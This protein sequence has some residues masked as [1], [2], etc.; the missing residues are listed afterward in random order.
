MKTKCPRAT[1]RLNLCPTGQISVKKANSKEM[2]FAGLMWPA[3]RMLPPRD[4][5][6]IALF[7]VKHQKILKI[8]FSF[9][10][11]DF[12]LRL[13]PEPNLVSPVGKNE[14]QSAVASNPR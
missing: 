7:E 12:T 6:K 2:A 3:G 10:G 4:H 8:I 13:S 9:L 14:R 11:P 5:K 1:L